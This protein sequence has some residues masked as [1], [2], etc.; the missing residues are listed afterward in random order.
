MSYCVNPTCHSNS[1]SELIPN[2]PEGFLREDKQERESRFIPKILLFCGHSLCESCVQT[3]I[4]SGANFFKCLKC[5]ISTD[6]PAPFTAAVK[7][8]KKENRNDTRINRLNEGCGDVIHYDAYSIGR[9]F[10]I[11]QVVVSASPTIN[12]DG[13]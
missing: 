10:D 7:G 11:G 9:A 12:L 2:G 4:A 13:K 3:T 1:S 6:F 8:I 5:D